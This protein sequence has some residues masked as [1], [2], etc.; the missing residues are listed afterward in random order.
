MS[1]KK[2]IW[3]SLVILLAA[4]ANPGGADENTVMVKEVIEVEH[5][6]YLLVE[7]KKK[8]FWMAAPAMVANPGERYSYQGGMEMTDFYS[9]E[10]DRTFEKVLFVDALFPA[11]GQTGTGMAHGMPGTGHAMPGMGHGMGTEAQESTPGSRTDMEKMQVTVEHGEGVTPVGDIF[12]DPGKLEGKKIRVTGV[13]TK[14]S[15]AI[16]NRNWIHLQDG[17]ESAE[18]F[19]MLVTS[20]E[21]FEGGELVTLEGV[22]ATDL[23]FG[24]GYTY[25]VLLEKAK[26]VR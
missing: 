1:A 16:M 9:Q 17:T 7:G 10:L 4:C 2:L 26:A 14:F 19:D 6:T 24:Y 25:E 20:P 21:H 18:K 13:V 8:E 22:I 5:Y 3:V 11:G 23:D 15:P 12:A